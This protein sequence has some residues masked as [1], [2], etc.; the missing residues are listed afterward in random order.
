MKAYQQLVQHVL[1][2]GTRKENRTG[3]DTVST[4][5][6]NYEVN[7]RDGFPLLTTKN[8]SW[9]NIV[10]EMLWFLSGQTDI[11]ILQR[12][13]CKFWDAWADENGKVPSAYGSFWTNFPPGQ[14][15][16]MVSPESPV[17]RT[18]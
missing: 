16:E 4:F 15:P 9:K 12:H 6:Y 18:T 7:L 1:D 8:V 17:A 5:N 10:C 3:V 13:N 2:N 11:S 14:E